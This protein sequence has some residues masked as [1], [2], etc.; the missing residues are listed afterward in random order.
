MRGRKLKTMGQLDGKTA[1]VTGAGSG[2][3]QAAA[4]A[5]AAEGAVAIVT[6]LPDR[7]D[8]AEATVAAI[9]QAGGEAHAVAL[10]VLDLEQHRGLRRNG[11]RDQRPARHPR[12]QCRGQHPP[13]RL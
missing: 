4:T 12:Q 13:P 10:N 1:L 2:L 5:L 9:K 8:R 3:G 11:R 7:L 6:E